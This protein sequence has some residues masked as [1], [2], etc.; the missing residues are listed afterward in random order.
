MRNSTSTYTST[1]DK[2]GKSQTSENGYPALRSIY[3]NDMRGSL[4]SSDPHRHFIDLCENC[5][6]G[7]INYLG[8]EDRWKELLEEAKHYQQ[9]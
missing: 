1:C 3:L 9:Y 8:A 6:S 5:F 4:S 2:C 7:M